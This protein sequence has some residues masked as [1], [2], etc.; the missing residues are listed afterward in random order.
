MV[1][2]PIIDDVDGAGNQLINWVAEMNAP[3]DPQNDWS[4]PG[5][6][7]DFLPVYADWRYDWLDVAAL[8]RNADTILE[9]PMVDKDPIPQ[10]SFGRVTL[11]GDAAHPMY[12][13][14]STGS[15]QAM[16][17]ARALAD[18]L[19]QH[20][21]PQDALLAYEAARRET[22]ATIVRTNRSSPPDF[23]NIRVE[24]LTGDKPFARLD[25]YISQDELRALSD[26]YKQV[27]GYALKDLAAAR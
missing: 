22:T 23:I 20:A 17:D 14:G 18:C 6:L 3:T 9:Y 21:V 8:I 26:G 15:A 7:E 2:Y 19:V 5:R 27:A 24:Q 13:R 1:I 11:V 16:V 10:W 4:K 12:P 25:D